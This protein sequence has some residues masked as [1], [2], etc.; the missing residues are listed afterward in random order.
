M[1][2]VLFMVVILVVIGAIF[3]TFWDQ[4]RKSLLNIIPPLM[5]LQTD[6]MH[7]DP[8]PD[9]IQ[10]PIEPIEPPIKPVNPPLQPVN[11]PLQPLETP[12]KPVNPPLD[13]ILPSQTVLI[14]S[15]LTQRYWSLDKANNRIVTTT[16][17]SNSSRWILE[18]GPFEETYYIRPES[19]PRQAVTFNYGNEAEP[20]LYL[21]SGGG[22]GTLWNWNR[23]G[24]KGDKLYT[25]NAFNHATYF[26]TEDAENHYE[27]IV[28]EHIDSPAQGFIIS[29]S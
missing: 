11:P 10:P 7:I 18:P 29:S 19:S 27:L 14:R 12:I 24:P 22:R 28:T 13:P 23:L 6:L 4:K 15:Q 1:A 25:M 5:P 9:I 8:L 17:N 20:P 16:N 3:Y 26:I 21:T 2:D